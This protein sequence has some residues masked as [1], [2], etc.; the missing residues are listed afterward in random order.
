MTTPTGRGDPD[1]SAGAGQRAEL[2]DTLELLRRAEDLSAENLTQ[3]EWSEERKLA[4]VRDF[5][6][7]QDA[8]RRAGILSELRWWRADAELGSRDVAAGAGLSDGVSANVA[9]DASIHDGLSQIAPSAEQRVPAE[10]QAVLDAYY[11]SL[12]ERRPERRD[13]ETPASP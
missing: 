2:T 11:R 7:L 9:G 8:A 12:A 1:S 13:G 5:K 4:F 3:S 10:L 6:R